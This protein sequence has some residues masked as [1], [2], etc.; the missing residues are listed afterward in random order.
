M[1]SSASDGAAPGAHA[2]IVAASIPALTESAN[3]TAI[4]LT[5]MIQIEVNFK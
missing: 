3:P 1:L 4:G 5:H 2:R